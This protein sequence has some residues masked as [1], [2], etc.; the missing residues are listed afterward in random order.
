MRILL[1]TNILVHSYNRASLYQK[2]ASD[3]VRKAVR[4]EIEA[5]IAPQILYEF[6][7]VVTDRKRVEHPLSVDE[8]VDICLDLWECRGIEKVNPTRMAQKEVFKFTKQLKLSKGEIFDCVLAVTAK[9][10]DVEMIYTENVD[11][12]KAY[13]F[14]KVSNPLV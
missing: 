14:L 6:F 3:V 8:A 4:G 9:E 10:N 2:R 5:C 1:D 11:D 13:S 7:A 12:F